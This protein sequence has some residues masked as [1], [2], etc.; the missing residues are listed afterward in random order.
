VQSKLVLV[1]ANSALW[2]CT[3]ILF[4]SA[5][6]LKVMMVF[7]TPMI[8]I[9]SAHGA[10]MA[11]M[12]IAHIHV[13]VISMTDTLIKKQRLMFQNLK[14]LYLNKAVQHLVAMI[15]MIGITLK[16]IGKIERNPRSK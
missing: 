13:D 14:Q 9:W 5:I 1:L 16:S 6:I 10:D 15:M 7:Y 3:A 11:I 12:V 2:I 4:T 8:H